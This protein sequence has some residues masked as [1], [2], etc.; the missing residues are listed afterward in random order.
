MISP[1]GRRRRKDVTWVCT[2]TGPKH[3]STGPHVDDRSVPT[4]SKALTDC[5]YVLHP[6][7]PRTT[8]AVRLSRSRSVTT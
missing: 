7:S 4:M 2:R 8:Q 6:G 5:A 1:L 3:T